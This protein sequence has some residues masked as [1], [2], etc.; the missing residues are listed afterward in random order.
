[1]KSKKQDV[2]TAKALT[3]E[4]LETVVGGD[5]PPCDYSDANL[6]SNCSWESS[7]MNNSGGGGGGGS[8]VQ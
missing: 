6:S 1:M 8:P 3:L 2:L 4:E 5:D 7:D